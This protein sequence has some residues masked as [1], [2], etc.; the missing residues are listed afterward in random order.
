MIIWKRILL[1]SGLIFGLGQLVNAQSVGYMENKGQWDENIKARYALANGVAWFYED[2][3]RI[4]IIEETVFLAGVEAAHEAPEDDLVVSGHAY[5]VI[6]GQKN[7]QVD[8]QLSSRHKDYA[9]FFLGN[10]RA[11]WA[12]RVGIY[13]ALNYSS[14]REGI[15]LAWTHQN[16]NMKYTFT[17]EPGTDPSSIFLEYAAI[18]S[19]SIVQGDLHIQLPNMSVVEQKPYAYQVINGSEVEVNCVFEVRG[20]RVQFAI[21]NYDSFQ[22]LY[23]DPV[24][25]GSTNIGATVSTFGHSATFDQ[26]GNII[27]GGRPFGQGYP[28][29]TGS[30]QMNF[31][32]GSVDIGISKLNDD[33]SDLLWS[34]Y[35]GGSGQEFVHSLVVNGFNDVVVYG[36]TNSTDY[37]VSAS[38]VDTSY[39][40]SFDICIT[41]ISDS[42]DALI[43]STYLGGESAD[44][45]NIIS[46]V[47]YASFKGEVVC[48]AYSNVFIAST[49]SSDSIQISSTAYATERSGLQDGY[50]AKLNYNLSSLEFATYLGDSLNDGAFNLKPAK[51]G[52]IYVVGVTMSPNFPTTAGAE[53]EVYNGGQSDGFITRL[54]AEGTSIIQ[55][56]FIRSDTALNDADRGLFLQI[57][58][59]GE[60]YVL[61]T[62]GGSIIADTNRYSAPGTNQASFIRK[63]NKDL[64][65]IHWTATFANLSHSAFLVDNCKNIYAAGN[66]ASG[67]GNYEL[68]SNAVQPSPAGFYI[69]V[70]DQEADSLIHGTYFGTGGSHVDGGTSRFDKRGA[71][72]QATCTNGFS[73]PQTAGAWSGNQNGGTYDLTLF[74][75]DFEVEAAVANAQVAPNSVGCIPHTVEFTNFGSQGLTHL[76][77][78]GD[79]DTALSQT[80]THT[81][82]V[83]GQYEVL[84]VIYDTIG[85]VLSDTA[86]LII[87]VYDTASIDILS[88]SAVCSETVMLYVESPYSTFLWSDG[89]FGDELHATTSG[90]YWVEVENACGTFQD[91]FDVVIIPPY[92]FNLIPDTGIC[93][94]GFFLEG[95][96]SATQYL[97]STG[98]TT[99]ST[100][101]DSTGDYILIASNEFCSDTD[102]VNVRI[103]YTNFN[104]S[105]T[106]IC[107]QSVELSVVSDEGTIAWSTGDSTA[108]ITVT[109]EGT[110]WVLLENGFCTTVD[111]IRVDLSPTLVDLGMDT[112]ICSP[113]TVSAFDPTLVSY[114]WSTGDTLSQVNV[115]TS[116]TL[117]VIG[118][119]ELCADT[120]SVNITL[121]TLSFSITEEL[122]CD[123][124]SHYL[125]APGPVGASFSWDTGDTTRTTT[126]YGSGIYHVTISTEHCALSD[127]LRITFAEAP[128]FDIGDDRV[129]CDG[130]SFRISVDSVWSTVRWN[131]GDTGRSIL[132]KDSGLV[133]ASMSFNGCEGRDSINVTWRTLDPDS[134]FLVPNVMTPNA[135][136]INDV[137]GL[138]VV[139]PSLITEYSLL[140]YNRW[141]V[142]LFESAYIN[143]DWDG[144][145]PSG[146]PAEVG[147]YYYIFRANTVCT[148]IPVI[149]VKDH[150]TVIR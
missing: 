83:P 44:G 85:C 127:S 118:R 2:R 51:D 72:Y 27:G 65:S 43:G 126:V 54:D 34:T 89:S 7:Q 1:F 145:M 56:T 22:P 93:E 138:H 67:N 62:S 90:Q 11:R 18:R 48:D 73:F 94:P 37:P 106:V 87:T 123:R 69:I 111:T 41:I 121:E 143:H 105:D 139:N 47:P 120:D 31:A 98:D 28:T 131:T 55:S 97:W 104:T 130:E 16:G 92:E 95:P 40:G 74:K 142:L 133:Y 81:Y 115:D 124:D 19:L 112:V 52:T 5:E 140:V 26:F 36:K 35:I 49:T 15:D 57:D 119:S 59:D 134:F 91:T 132:V 6:F 13:D 76:W 24:V 103:S 14:V 88:D 39:N 20:N 30:F 12:S 136:G 4:P 70:L 110:Y 100:P 25:V 75:I 60:I 96:S 42:G 82:T 137:L 109:E 58:R 80:P 71:V 32:G 150:V 46:G 128:K 33:A 146:E 61:G 148:D 78:F 117:W 17:V 79:G 38:A 66:G 63:Y 149:E 8:V 101:V 135:D 45:A 102:T 116:M 77:N 114:L 86:T 68:T 10:N 125:V 21:G 53:D 64:D 144:R 23:I 113:M 29:D 3:V 99:Q 50:V 9:N 129:I 147:T 141:G 84:Y 108:A 107:A 122:V